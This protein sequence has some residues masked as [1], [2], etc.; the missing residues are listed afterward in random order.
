MSAIKKADRI[1]PEVILEAYERNAGNVKR[2]AKEL[3]IGSWTVLRNVRKLGKGKKPIAGGRVKAK[4]ET[5]E[6]PKTGEVK[7]YILTSAQ[8]NTHRHEGIWRNLLALA[9]HYDATILIGTYSYNQNAYGELAVKRGTKK[10][11]EK[12]LWYDEELKPY[13]SDTRVKLGDGLVWCGEFNALPT[14]TNPLSGLESYSERKSTIFPH[15]KMAMRSIPTMLD[16]PAKL[17][18]TTGTVTKMNYIQKRAGTIAEHHHVY[19]AVLVEVNAAGKWWV[20]QLNAESRGGKIQ[21]LDVIVDDGIIT[22]GNRVE[23]IT[24]GDLH[25]TFADDEVVEVSLDMLDTL[26]PKTQFMHDVLEGSSINHHR[27]DDPHFKFMTWLRGLNR[28]AEEMK[29]TAALMDRYDRPETKTVVVESNHDN[30]WIQRWLRDYDFKK[31]PPNAQF[32]LKAQVYMYE[33]LAKKKMPRDISMLEWCLKEVGLKSTPKFLIADESYRICD[34]KI[35]CGMHGH[36][37][38]GG[39]QG[40]PSN[41]SK[42]GRRCNIAHTHQAGIYDGLYMAGTTS[43]LRWSYNQGPSNWTHSHVVTYPN[44]KR[45]IIT[46]FAGAW[47]AR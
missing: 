38:P 44:G 2:T 6:L 24:W 36:L 34:D 8:N 21:D 32:Y 22:T 16:A 37:G 23:A 35:E 46:I 11:S 18:F 41:L 45:T 30:P 15:A 5:A 1:H 39:S 31:D 12:E 17:I 3:G 26:R 40:T 33:E 27:K 20:R 19:G 10:P 4:L 43:K 7:R 42:M 14:A 25:A 28:V 9:A 47:R 29:R 13:F